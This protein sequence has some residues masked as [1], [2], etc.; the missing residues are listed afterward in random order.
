MKASS[1]VA[2]PVLALSSAGEP[3]ASTL[4]AF[5]AASQSN[6]SASSM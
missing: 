4:P 2:A 3:V 6:R 5:I 1:S